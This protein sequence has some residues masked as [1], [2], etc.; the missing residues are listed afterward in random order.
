MV[1]VVDLSP[2]G[3]W[4]LLLY[5]ACLLGLR[6]ITTQ[7][8][9]PVVAGLVTLSW[10]RYPIISVDPCSPLAL[11][12]TPTLTKR[13][14]EIGLDSHSAGSLQRRGPTAGCGGTSVSLWV[15]ELGLIISQHF[16]SPGSALSPTGPF[17]P[18][19]PSNMFFKH[20]RNTSHSKKGV[21]FVIAICRILIYR[22]S[23]CK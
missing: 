19:L 15:T 5:V 20:L 22:Y 11:F 9:R 23:I 1:C 21:Q 6:P 3:L 17:Q 14:D 10:S 4:E 2:P 8:G 7:E 12:N 18:R 13:R 16:L